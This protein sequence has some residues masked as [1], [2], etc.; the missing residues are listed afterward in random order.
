MIS[1]NE[2]LGD[3]EELNDSDMTVTLTS[4][5]IWDIM[6]LD[7]WDIIGMLVSPNMKTCNIKS[8]VQCDKTY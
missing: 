6:V 5:C 8:S 1:L 4:G 2:M 7:N 3:L